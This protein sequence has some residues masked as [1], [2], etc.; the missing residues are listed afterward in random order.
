MSEGRR[1]R[2][3]RENIVQWRRITEENGGYCVTLSWFETECLAIPRNETGQ[4]PA[5]GS[6][7]T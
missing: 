5:S 1:L 7:D 3:S 2:S 4:R 6:Q